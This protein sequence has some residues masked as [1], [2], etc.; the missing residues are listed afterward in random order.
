[1]LPRV[2]PVVAVGLVAAAFG[3][4]GLLAYLHHLPEGGDTAVY[5]AGASALL[6]GYPLYDSDTL[7]TE[8]SY[9]QLPFTYAP[10]AALLFVPLA[11]FPVQIAWGLLGVLS[12]LAL[13][14]VA[15]LV[16]RKVARRPAWLSPGLGATIVFGA[17]Q[18]TEP[19]TATVG[20]G[21]I[22][23]ALMALVVLDVLVVCGSSGRAGRFCGVLIGVA[24]AIKLTPLIFVVH[25][26]LTGRKADAARA[27]GTFAGL[28][29]LML[30][31]AP[32]D[33]VRFWTHTVYDSSR[34]GP[35]SWSYNQSL[36]SLVRRLTDS[37]SWSQP[38]AYGIGAVLAVGA[39]VLVL[40]YHRRGRPVHAM[41]VTAF[42]ALLISPVSW[43]H[44][45]VW[46]VPLL[47]LLL[48][49][50]LSGNRFAQVLT[51]VT[52]VVFFLRPLHSITPGEHGEAS[53]NAV[54]F[55]LSNLYVLFPIVV[56]LVL[57]LRRRN[58]PEVGTSL[59]QQ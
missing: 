12:D 55:V 19:V 26:L 27:A 5:Q 59:T 54:T 21:Q 35:T 6:H 7:P 57:L 45:W 48:P 22:N 50:A 30:L 3:V 28:Q 23:A 33:T 16:L 1:M 4:R 8:P 20:Y 41:L 14:G 17:T 49:E 29:A 47:A 25:L 40:R 53:L 31:I 42:L 18:V 34:I 2:L 13:A 9:A 46:I 56:G 58:Q 44:H 52:L 43:V 37:A 24:A 38:L 39:A 15:F 10:F 51:P 36:G 11:F 32:H